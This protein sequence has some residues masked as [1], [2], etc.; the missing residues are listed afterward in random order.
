MKKNKK[1]IS[2]ILS[3]MMTFTLLVSCTGEGHI[4]PQYDLQ[5]DLEK[6]NS[7]V[8]GP[9]WRIEDE[10]SIVYLHGTI[11]LGDKE[12]YP[13]GAMVEEA[14][15][16]CDYLVLEEVFDKLDPMAM[17]EAVSYPNGD[18]IENHLSKESIQIIK[19]ICAENGV[20]YDQIKYWTPFMTYRTL[21]DFLMES[22]NFEPKYGIDNYWL[23]RARL[24]KKEI[25]ALD[26][27]NEVY[28]E[29]GKLSDEDGE[30]LIQSLKL[31]EGE[32]TS[33]AD[34]SM[35]EAWKNAELD[36]IFAVEEDLSAYTEEE[37]EVYNSVADI[38]TEYEKILIHDR[39]S[40]WADKIEGYLK[41]NKDYFVAGGTAHFYGEG[42]VIELLE[43]KGLKITRLN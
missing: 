10:D 6:E 21:I 43:A 40:I 15:D 35:W 27:Y 3:I 42:S 41:D 16:S 13:L 17:T 14:F 32:D 28:A 11:H 31:S 34:N 8:I 18:T 19:N 23:Y 33:E 38:S 22:P 20:L 36:K 24:S 12:I 7:D 9:L 4:D 39:N 29:L 5:L 26:D 30:L 37:L 25:L 1:V 2:L